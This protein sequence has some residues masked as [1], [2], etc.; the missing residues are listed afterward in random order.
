MS[1]AILSSQQQYNERDVPQQVEASNHFQN[2][3]SK[4]ITLPANAEVA[5][6]NAK[7]NRNQNFSI[8]PGTSFK[9]YLG[10]ELDQTKLLRQSTS[11]PMTIDLSDPNHK[12]ISY[13]E[14]RQRIQDSLNED[15]L[16]PDMIGR[17]TL[18][19]K[20]DDTS[21]EAIGFK[22]SYNKAQDGFDNSPQV[23]QLWEAF[24][25][26]SLDGFDLAVHST[27]GRRITRRSLGTPPEL[28]GCIAVGVDTCL[29]PCGGVC[30][31]QPSGGVAND[32]EW[33]V[34]L[35]R[36][37]QITDNNNGIPTD[38]VEDVYP[39]WFERNYDFPFQGYY[40]YVLTRESDGKIHVYQTGWNGKV[41]EGRNGF[42]WSLHEIE[43]WN[44]NSDNSDYSDESGPVV[45]T[46]FSS[47]QFEVQNE[48]MVVQGYDPLDGGSWKTI[49]QPVT[50][51]VAFNKVTRPVGQNE[52][53]LYPVVELIADDDHMDFIDFNGAYKPGDIKIGYYTENWYSRQYYIADL[54]GNPRLLQ[55][56]DRRPWNNSTRDP[57]YHVWKGL[58]EDNEITTIEKNV[59]M[60][61]ANEDLYTPITLFQSPNDDLRD[62][63]G[64]QVAIVNENNF[65]S[66]HENL[67]EIRFESTTKPG[68]GSIREIF[69]KLDSLTIESF[70]GAMSDISK[71]IYS[72]PRFDN[73]GGVVGPLF[74]ENNDRYYLKLNNVAPIQLNRLDCS[75][76]GVNN[77]LA[78]GLYGNTVITLHFRKSQN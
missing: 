26:Q 17:T 42:Q 20:Q 3:F 50:T 69:I 60:I 6:V 25:D 11:T 57:H 14:A 28:A 8:G 47:F 72:I 33:A 1:L 77:R 2:H 54:A 37:L 75:L 4:P 66:L 15:L 74:F 10:D 12:S 41:D 68:V 63:L 52:W 40:D 34:G 71:I 24:S 56:L 53:A 23:S 5:V 43:Y 51:E 35:M 30:H 44:A 70:N 7:I 27:H 16:H 65:G 73:S 55:E 36:P 61:I 32:T 67:S 48:N 38:S 29:S 22:F 76:V 62:L 49:I 31:F 45:S 46:T 13:E 39:E 18:T 59:V 64:Y 19:L 21:G 9:V 58:Q 78:Q